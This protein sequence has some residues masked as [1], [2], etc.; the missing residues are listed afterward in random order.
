MAEFLTTAGI[1][2]QLED[3]IKGARR[4]LF[5]ISPFLRVNDRLKEFLEEKDLFNRKIPDDQGDSNVVAMISRRF[6]DKKIDI[7]IVYGKK[8]LKAAE[9]EWLESLTSIRT[10]FRKNLHAKCYL[11]EE[12]ALLTSMNLYE[13]SQVNNDEMGL[14]VHR[15]V[16]PELYTKIYEEA[17]RLAS[18]GDVDPTATKVAVDEHTVERPKSTGARTAAQTPKNGFCIRCG[19]TVPANPDR[20]YCER[21]FKSWNRY[22]NE[23]Y[24]EKGCHTCGKEHEATMS[25]PLCLTCYRKH[26]NWVD[27][28]IK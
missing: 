10:S 12:K 6:R 16:E 17:M 8:E 3:I 9:N 11:N 7:H 23:T 15:K 25:K 18:K 24:G 21:C 13:F 2:S 19:D 14:L 27:S 20:P 26:K 4:H 28:T 5:L 22:K 1:S